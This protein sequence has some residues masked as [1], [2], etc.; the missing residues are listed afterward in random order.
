MFLTTKQLNITFKKTNILDSKMQTIVNPVNCV[1]VM[2]A[3]L[4][5]A[6]RRKYPFM[7]Q[8]YRVACKRGELKIGKP[9]LYKDTTPWI[10][11]FPTKDHWRRRS[12]LSHIKTGLAYLAKH[13]AEMGITSL[14]IPPLGCGLGGLKWAAV[15][16]LIKKYLGPLDI[17]IEIYKPR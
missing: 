9:W 2:G 1:G 12:R 6:Y 11:N 15:L 16:P 17:P 14:A 8:A 4:A 3:G 7:Y 10:L 13:A 5:L